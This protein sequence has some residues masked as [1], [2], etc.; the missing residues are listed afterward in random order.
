M[1][2]QQE[3]QRE[4]ADKQRYTPAEA[5]QK[6]AFDEIVRQRIVAYPRDD[7]YYQPTGVGHIHRRQLVR[8]GLHP[9]VEIEH[10]GRRA[11]CEEVSQFEHRQR[12]TQRYNI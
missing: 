5:Y 6:L 1:Y 4:Q 10:A 11:A 8:R 7:A 9:G 2:G 12:E 3:C